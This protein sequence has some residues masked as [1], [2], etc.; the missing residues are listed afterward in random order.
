[1]YFERVK[2]WLRNVVLMPTT[3]MKE[4][5]PLFSWRGD[6]T[7]EVK[8]KKII[9]EKLKVSTRVL[10]GMFHLLAVDILLAMRQLTFLAFAQVGSV[11]EDGVLSG[12]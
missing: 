2:E 12:K 1:M 11:A 6:N 9:G 8:K 7:K 3:C 5:S 4:P 10:E